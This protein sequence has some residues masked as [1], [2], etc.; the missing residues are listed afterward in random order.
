MG[1]LSACFAVATLALAACGSDNAKT[2]AGI[3]IIDSAPPD[4]K[5]WM[6][7]PPGPDYDLTC[8]NAAPPTTATD[9]I[10]IAGTTQSLSMNG[11]SEVADATVDVFKNGTA[12]AV[13]TVTSNA[14]GDFTTGNIAT[15]GTP[16]N[17]HIRASKAAYRTTY[18]YP[19]TVVAASITGVPVVM[20]SNAAFM[21]VTQFLGAQDDDN[22]GV[23]LFAIT[24]CNTTEQ[25][26]IA[27]STVT[28]QQNG[29]DVGTKLGLGVAD[30]SLEGIFIV[31]NVP[32]G[33]TQ[34]AAN[35]NGMA[36]P[37]RTVR[38]Y[39]KPTATSEGTLTFTAI[40]PGG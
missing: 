5:V 36:F 6:D 22:N 27:E 35:Y 11:G 12:A 38:A 24:D 31:T 18:M 9:P 13:A 7:A 3:K 2:D 40:R 32:D 39:K 34:I 37:V 20:F 1:K 10:T 14:T 33:D 15:G 29:A 21:Q 30:Q 25:T 19:P 28:V 8:L 4:M 17:G 23:L 26:L 16:L